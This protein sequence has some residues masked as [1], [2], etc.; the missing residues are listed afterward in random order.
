MVGTSIAT[1][2]GGIFGC[3]SAYRLQRTTI[4]FYLVLVFI[5]TISQCMVGVIFYRSS[6]FAE[7]DIDRMW[8]T[9]SPTKINAWQISYNCC[10]FYPENTT[11]DS[12]NSLPTVIPIIRREITIIGTSDTNCSAVIA[13]QQFYS[14][15][16]PNLIITISNGCR[17]LL[18]ESR[19]SVTIGISLFLWGCLSIELL[20]LTFGVGLLLNI[21]L[22]KNSHLTQQNQ[23]EIVSSGNEKEPRWLTLLKLEHK[24]AENG[25]KIYVRSPELSAHFKPRTFTESSNISL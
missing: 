25:N 2:F 23:F 13:T 9:E 12:L 18:I 17:S 15:L 7:R 11:I 24:E 10:G 4:I 22:K 16:D 21:R 8:A 3:S 20:C 5:L 1:L 14:T 6:Q 19:R